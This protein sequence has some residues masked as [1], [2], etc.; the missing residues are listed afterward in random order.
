MF[1]VV[2][3]IDWEGRGGPKFVVFNTYLTFTRGEM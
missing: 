3:V 2:K 1:C